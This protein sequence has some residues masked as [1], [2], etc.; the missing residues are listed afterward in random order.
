[1]MSSVYGFS[2]SKAIRHSCLELLLV[3]LTLSSGGF[4][5]SFS[6][7]ISSLFDPSVYDALRTLHA[8]ICTGSDGSAIKSEIESSNDDD[9]TTN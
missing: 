9:W 8:N 5:Q 1:M 2:E 3:F 6:T 4:P 7:R